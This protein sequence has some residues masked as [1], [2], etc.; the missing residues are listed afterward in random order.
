MNETQKLISEFHRN[1]I[2]L[3]RINLSEWKSKPYV[4]IRIWVLEDPAKAASAVPTKK[5]IRLSIDLLPKLIDALNEASR[6]LK[7]KET[8]NKSPEKEE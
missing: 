5:G 8:G 4:D 3:V 1:S 6:I 7:E 2:E